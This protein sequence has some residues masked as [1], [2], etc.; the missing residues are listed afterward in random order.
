[1]DDSLWF[2]RMMLYGLTGACASVALLLLAW[3][4]ITDD[5]T[6]GNDDD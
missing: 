3:W 4:L 6:G 2:V 5:D 1:M